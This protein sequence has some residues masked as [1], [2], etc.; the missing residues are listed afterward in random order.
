MKNIFSCKKLRQCYE[1]MLNELLDRDETPC[2]EE[3]SIGYSTLEVYL[4]AL[5]KYCYD[6][7]DVLEDHDHMTF[8]SRILY[9]V[10]LAHASTTP[11]PSDNTKRTDEGD[12]AVPIFIIDAGQE[13]GVDAVMFVLFII[14]QLV[15]CE[16]YD[17]MLEN[18]R[19]VILPAINP[20]GQEYAK[21][22]SATWK[23]NLTPLTDDTS[24]GVDVSRNFDAQWSACPRVDWGFSPIY[25]GPTAAS[26]NET[27]FLQNIL[28][29]HKKD[30]K[31]YLSIRRD[32]HSISYPY[33]HSKTT[34]S[35]INALSK[36]AAEVSSRVN[37]RAGGV[38]VFTNSSI[39]ESEGK[40][41]CGHSVD[42]AYDLGIYLS[43]EMRVFLSSNYRIMSM[44]QTMP[45]GYEATLRNAY[46]SGI[47]ELYNALTNEKKYGR[48]K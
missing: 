41:H 7:F 15:A 18:V 4:K 26:E 35:N 37:Q 27:I 8:E 12:D 31:M 13:A 17:H 23:K 21:F 2:I 46:F 16:E 22:T 20:D 48:L 9:E 6:V 19:W 11:T 3:A 25:P 30:A 10:H 28:S 44:F 36:I 24:F 42:F 38:H 32:G 40:A 33:A 47:K 29:K 1:D 39:Y 45:K 34:P 43:F 14:E 5:K